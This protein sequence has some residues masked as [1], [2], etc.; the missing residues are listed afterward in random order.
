MSMLLN[1]SLAELAQGTGAGTVGRVPT[2]TTLQ[3]LSPVKWNESQQSCK[4][5]WELTSLQEGHN[6]LSSPP[7]MHSCL[8]LVLVLQT[9][10][11]TVLGI[12]RDAVRTIDAQ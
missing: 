5:V 8:V 4:A 2:F 3:L 11:A 1:R 6:S 10:F 12:H 7:Q 9:A